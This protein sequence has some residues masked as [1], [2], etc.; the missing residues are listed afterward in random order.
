MD[1]DFALSEREARLAMER[2]S[3]TYIKRIFEAVLADRWDTVDS[4][5]LEARTDG[6][7]M[8]VAVWGGLPNTVKERLR[9]EEK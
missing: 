3:R 4:L 6:E 2:A 9:G 5:W 7:W 8:A 1:A